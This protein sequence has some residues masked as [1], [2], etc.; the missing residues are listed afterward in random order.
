MSDL[1]GLL[2]DVYGDPP[3]KS[4]SPPAAPPQPPPAAQPAPPPAQPAP[5]SAPEPGPLDWANEPTPAQQPIVI[6]DTTDDLAAALS[7]ALAEADTTD[8]WVTVA[9]E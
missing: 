1:S 6:A 8:Q 3:D 7:E 9:P 4:T 2:G 5:P